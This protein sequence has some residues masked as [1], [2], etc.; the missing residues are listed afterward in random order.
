M[1]EHISTI[2][3]LLSTHERSARDHGKKTRMAVV[4]FPGRAQEP[5]GSAGVPPRLLRKRFGTEKTL[6][7]GAA[8]PFPAP[9]KTFFLSLGD[10]GS[11]QF[12]YKNDDNPV[13]KN[14]EKRTIIKNE[15]QE[16]SAHIILPR[17]QNALLGGF[18]RYYFSRF[19]I[20][21][22]SSGIDQAAFQLLIRD[23]SRT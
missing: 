11:L 21:S 20:R 22:T 4:L 3:L 8:G 17:E 7:Y 14:T 16:R 2:L 12:F 23:L 9:K 19:R 18:A 6:S 10:F 5:S 15:Q 1:N 13:C